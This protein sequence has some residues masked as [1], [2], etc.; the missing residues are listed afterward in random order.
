VL[1]FLTGPASLVHRTTRREWLRLGSI[2]GLGLPVTMRHGTASA[3]SSRPVSPGFG[4]AKSVLLI[5]TSGGQ[6]QIDTWDPKPDAPEEVRGAFASIRTS[7]PGT[8]FTEHLPRLAR[9]AHLFTVVRSVS[10]DDLDHGS[11]SYL[12]LT[13]QFHPRKSSNPPPRPTDAPTYG[14]IVQRVRPSPRLPYSAVHLNGPALVPEIIAPG[15]AGGLLGHGCDPLLLGDVAHDDVALAGLDPRPELPPVR[16]DA[17]RSLLQTLDRYQQALEARTFGEM[18]GLYR[19]AYDLLSAPGFR[20]AFD[21]HREPLRV[22]DAYGWH[23]PGQ[24]CLL[25][26]RLVEAEVPFITVIWN[27]TN[28]GQDKAPDQTDLYGWDTH[29]DIF[30]ALRY[31]LL[32]RFDATF[33]TLLSDLEQRGLL[34]S[35]LVVCLGEFGRAP[36]VARET[37]FAGSAPGRKHWAAVYSIVVAGAGVAQGALFGKSDRQGAYPVTEP[38]NPCDVAATLFAAL[39]IDPGAHYLDP[40]GRPFVISPGL[41]LAGLYR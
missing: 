1:R 33:A 23:R 10:H 16:L 28:R 20:R 17:R 40:A 36:R 3:H 2:L 24:A 25:A 39:G 27:H 41:P 15:Q 19:Q 38:V 7:V 37:T 12:A 31:R 34:D 30:E 8:W 5:Y 21:L 14:A 32:P 22:R 13:G 9:L 18:N 35:T 6:S 26:R 29:N 4:R 11:A